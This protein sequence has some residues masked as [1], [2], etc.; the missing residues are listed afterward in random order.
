MV[1][2]SEHG[3]PECSMWIPDNN[4]VP[5]SSVSRSHHASP[6]DASSTNLILQMVHHSTLALN[7]NLTGKA[8]HSRSFA[9]EMAEVPVVA[10][11]ELLPPGR[12]L[13]PLLRLRSPLRELLA[14]ASL[15]I[16]VGRVG[17][18]KL[19][20]LWGLELS[21]RVMSCHAMPRS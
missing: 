1:I 15:P 10:G 9:F 7:P 6:S 3:N 13:S 2:A 17:T 18:S 14:L 4:T 19:P 21:C 20:P 5:R 12:L 16:G 8:N 11:E